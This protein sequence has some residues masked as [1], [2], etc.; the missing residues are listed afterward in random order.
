[1]VNFKQK[2]KH[3]NILMFGLQ[4]SFAPLSKTSSVALLLTQLVV[5]DIYLHLAPD[6]GPLRSQAVMMPLR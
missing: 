5:R 2:L 3:L 4:S 1:M 6:I